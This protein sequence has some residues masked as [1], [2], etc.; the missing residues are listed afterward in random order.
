[1]FF[2]HVLSRQAGDLG[3]AF[4]DLAALI[5]RN[6]RFS[7]LNCLFSD[8]VRLYANRDYAREPDYYSLFKACSGN[9]W[10]I[11][12]EPLDEGM[13]WAMMAQGEFLE[14]ELED[15]GG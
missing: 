7:A 6:H 2:H 9:S 1:M 8:G 11:S 3:R 5:R 14:I 12:S 10:F 4:L 15:T 13:R